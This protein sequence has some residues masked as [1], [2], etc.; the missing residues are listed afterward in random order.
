[1]AIK[2]VLVRK[3]ITSDGREFTNETQACVHEIS[4]EFY[5]YMTGDPIEFDEEYFNSIKLTVSNID[6]LIEI[7]NKLTEDKTN[8]D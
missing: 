3:W 2:E 6:K 8:E 5:V 1:M 7:K 4:L